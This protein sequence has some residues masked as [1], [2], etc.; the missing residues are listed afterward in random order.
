MSEIREAS[1][2]GNEQKSVKQDRNATQLNK[3]IK[4]GAGSFEVWALGIVIVIGGQYYSWNAGLVCGV[5]SYGIGVLLMV[6]G[7]ITLVLN[8]S[9]TTSGLPFEGG[10]Y[11]LARC[12]IS[13]YWGYMIGCLEIVEFELSDRG[14]R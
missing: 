10:S 7:Y 6:I 11:A 14:A 1:S 2:I 3:A 13:N 9:E 8:I 4:F 5:G 12:T